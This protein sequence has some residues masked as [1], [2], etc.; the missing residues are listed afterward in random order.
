VQSWFDQQK[1]FDWQREGWFIATAKKKRE[2]G[3]HVK[4]QYHTSQAAKGK[5]SAVCMTE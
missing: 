5:F 4:N 2:N 3:L 1:L